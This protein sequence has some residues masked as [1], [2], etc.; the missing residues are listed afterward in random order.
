MEVL[1]DIPIIGLLFQLVATWNNYFLPL[2][3]LN[4]SDLFP[5]TVGL[6]LWNK[7]ANAGGVNI[8]GPPA[9][10]PVAGVMFITSTAN[11]FR[12]QVAPAKDA[13]ELM[14]GDAARERFPEIS[15]MPVRDAIARAG[16]VGV[17]VAPPNKR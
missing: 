13:V 16:L 8:T 1:F 10:D 7:L 17:D 14:R 12:L 9:A 3:V 5:L 11:C 6:S 15:P 2:I 4:Q